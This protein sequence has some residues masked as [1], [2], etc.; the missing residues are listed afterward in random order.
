MFRKMFILKLMYATEKNIITYILPQNMHFRCDTHI[1]NND[2]KLISNSICSSDKDNKFSTVK[3]YNTNCFPFLDTKNIIV[4]KKSINNNYE[5]QQY[6]N[7]INLNFM[8]NC[9]KSNTQLNI[10]QLQIPKNNQPTSLKTIKSSIKSAKILKKCIKLALQQ[11]NLSKTLNIDKNKFRKISSEIYSLLTKKIHCYNKIHQKSSSKSESLSTF[12]KNHSFLIIKKHENNVKTHLNIACNSN[13]LFKNIKSTNQITHLLNLNSN[14]LKTTKTPFIKQKN[15]AQDFLF[16]P[17]KDKQKV[18]SSLENSNKVIEFK[19]NKKINLKNQ[20]FFVPKKR[21]KTSFLLNNTKNIVLQ[22][23]HLKSSKN[24]NL[25]SKIY[26]KL[27]LTKNKQGFKYKRNERIKLL[28]SNNLETTT[29]IGIKT[30]KKSLYSLENTNKSNLSVPFSLDFSKYAIHDYT[31]CKN[32]CIYDSEDNHEEEDIIP[33]VKQNFKPSLYK[34][35][36]CIPVHKDANLIKILN[37]KNEFP[38]INWMTLKDSNYDIKKLPDGLSFSPGWRNYKISEKPMSKSKKKDY[39]LIKICAEYNLEKYFTLIFN[40]IRINTF[41]QKNRFIPFEI[42]FHLICH[43]F[44]TVLNLG[45]GINCRVNKKSKYKKIIN[46]KNYNKLFRSKQYWVKKAKVLHKNAKLR[47]LK[48]LKISHSSFTTKHLYNLL[49]LLTF[50]N[51]TTISFVFY[52]YH[53]NF[54]NEIDLNLDYASKEK[55]NL[56]IQKRKIL[57]VIIEKYSKYLDNAKK[58]LKKRLQLLNLG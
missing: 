21:L 38:T 17:D 25:K 14:K 40:M 15:I 5:H 51:P 28:Q 37:T 27:E 9:K 52:V 39:F 11:I 29:C 49:L 2:Q 24:N 4:N 1:L 12:S 50:N 47:A 7:S 48:E 56:I 26:K 54:H 57:T 6:K 20:V 53:A 36:K 23:P 10:N 18:Y 31:N 32:I 3:I 34:E 58:I 55:R 30:L 16:I 45:I 13:D 44:C 43:H 22:N 35:K 19:T 41:T 33:A 46:N 42:C 8:Q